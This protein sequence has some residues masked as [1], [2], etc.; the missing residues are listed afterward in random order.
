MSSREKSLSNNS[1]RQENWENPEVFNIN[2][3]APRCSSFPYQSVKDLLQENRDSPFYQSLN[4]SWSFHWVSKPAERPIGFQS[5]YDIASWETIEVPSNVEMKGYGTPIYVNKQYPFPKNPPFIPHDN[6][7]V[8]SYKREFEIPRE[9]MEKEVFIHFAGVSSAAYYWINGVEVGYSQ[10]SKTPNEFCITPYIKEGTNTV[11][12]EVYRWC[13]G[14]Y[15]EGQDFWRLSGIERDV[16]LWCSPKTY[17]RDFFV[18]ATLDDSYKD[19]LLSI[20]IELAGDL[21]S[22]KEKRITIRLLSSG[23]VPALRLSEVTES[24]KLT[25]RARIDNP[26][27]WSAEKPHLYQLVIELEENGSITQ[28]LGCKLGFR[29]IEISNGQLK[30]N[31]RAIQIKGVN[32]HEH[33]DVNGHVISEESI[34]SDIRLMKRSNINAVRLGHY[35]NMARW[36]E[37]CDQY[38]LYVVDEANIE[39]HAMGVRFQDDMP[40]DEPTH[41][42]NLPEWREAHLERVKKMVETHKNH[43]CIITWSLGNEAGNGENFKAAYDWVK[44]RDDSRPVQYEQAGE[45]QNTDIVCPMYPKVDQIVEFAKKNDGRP[46]IMC[47]YAHAMGNSVGNIFKYWDAIEK[48]PNLQGG[49]IWDWVDQGLKRESESGETYWAYGG[50]FEPE[51]VPNDSNFCINGLVRPDRTPNPALWE[52]KKVYENIRFVP[53]DVKVGKVMIENNFD[54]TNLSEFEISWQLFADGHIIAEGEFGSLAVSPGE[55]EVLIIPLPEL[56]E[57]KEYLLNLLGIT[58]KE[59]HMIPRGHIVVQEQF[60]LGSAWNGYQVKQSADTPEIEE[61]EQEVIIKSGQFDVVW[62]KGLGLFRDYKYEGM[63]LVI[64][65]GKPQF[66][67]APTDN[68]FGNGMP[69]RLKIWKEASQ[70][71][72]LV[73]FD[74]RPQVNYIEVETQFA[75]PGECGMVVKVYRVYSNGEIEVHTRL[76]AKGGFPEIPR[77]GNSLIIEGDLNEVSWYGRGPYEN[78]VDRNCAALVGIYQSK[79]EDLYTPYIRP[80]ENGYRTDVRWVEFKNAKGVG[81][82]F[83]ADDLISFSA[84]HQTIFDFDPGEEKGQRHTKDIPFRPEV[85]L[86]IDFKQ[87]GVG[88]DD[89]WGAK[90]HEEFLIP[91]GTYEYSYLIRPVMSELIF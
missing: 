4:G 3:E 79:V 10:D 74:T 80:Q 31:N 1:G 90:P 35:P 82:R 42:S 48:Y 67:R 75:L 87:M 78:Y 91:P 53:I 36:Y 77:I 54:F 63:S 41:P 70:S 81:L 11:S 65:G 58:R 61:L 7:P 26:V 86:N 76:D 43:P 15:L 22:S 33:D 84:H 51:G 18:N 59:D 57:D 8:S 27:Q 38:G 13:D 60:P 56:K 83:E 32:R 47:E 28:V 50:D 49:F 85:Y 6:N 39:S 46:L 89:S 72:K 21:N 34:I 19:G 71:P 68:D 16:Y 45:D 88:G 73:S 30:V 2:Q 20:D 37:L 66:W 17:I 44:N 24:K 64:D 55:S 69:Q 25:F 9:W 62:D 5:D 23:E 29:R 40:Y 52:V 14:S 12:V